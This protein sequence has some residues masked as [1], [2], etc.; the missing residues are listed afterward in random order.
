MATIDVDRIPPLV[1]VKALWEK[2]PVCD[3][4]LQN[5]LPPH[6][7]DKQSEKLAKDAIAEGFIHYNTLRPIMVNFDSTNVD[8]TAYDGFAGA[9]TFASVVQELRKE[10]P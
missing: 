9:G 5:N 6:E 1:L 4:A 7:W 2:A 8:P 10:Y 3:F